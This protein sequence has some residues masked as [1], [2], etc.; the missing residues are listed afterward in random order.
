MEAGARGAR[1]HGGGD[2]VSDL[3]EH[4]GNA[5]ATASNGIPLKA[6]FSGAR[7]RADCLI[8]KSGGGCRKARP[9]RGPDYTQ[10]AARLRNRPTGGRD[11]ARSATTG[12][13]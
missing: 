7:A 10:A 8:R 13:Y 9:K 1:R 12:A 6:P 5:A 11:R 3:G 2:L 4:I